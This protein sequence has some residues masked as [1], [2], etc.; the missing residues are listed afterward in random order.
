VADLARHALITFPASEVVP[1]YVG[2]LRGAA[3]DAA[4]VVATASILAQQEAARA[5]LGIVIGA[6]SL[7]EEDRRLRRVLPRARIPSMEV[8]LAVHRDVRASPAVAEVLEHLA[9]VLRREP[10]G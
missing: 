5:G 8:W 10:L 9:R 6:V 3:G 4:V 1:S 7:L 2:W